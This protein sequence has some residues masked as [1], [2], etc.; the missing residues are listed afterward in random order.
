MKTQRTLP[1]LALTG[2]LVI[3]FGL[4]FALRHNTQIVTITFEGPWAF[5]SDP[6]DPGSIFAFAPK[7]ATHRDLALKFSAD[8]PERALAAGVYQVLL[9]ARPEAPSQTAIDPS[10]LQA[11]I[12]AQGVRHALAESDRYAIRL[13]RPEAYIALSTGQ[14]RAG[15]AYPPGPATE[16]KYAMD[17]A[18]RYR[19][20]TLA[21]FMVSSPDAG[22]G[23]AA[24]RVDGPKL[25]FAI[26]PLDGQMMDECELHN[27]EAFRDL[28]KLV[29]VKMFV[30]FE[31]FGSDCQATDPQNPAVAAK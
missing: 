31:K 3:A 15:S 26:R 7:T 10:I 24:V 22:G 14:M 20:T 2:I 4:F 5:A 21:G 30:D 17:A 11:R 27:R 29:G 25:S 23:F 19:A 18:L 13:P 6:A 16:K 28:A 8:E 12:D 9:H 1:L